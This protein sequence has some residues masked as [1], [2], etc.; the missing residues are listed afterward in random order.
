MQ[1][2]HLFIVLRQLTRMM[3]MM[4]MDICVWDVMMMMIVM[5]AGSHIIILLP[6]D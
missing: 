2:K 1:Q 6:M 4:Q 5:L 3:L